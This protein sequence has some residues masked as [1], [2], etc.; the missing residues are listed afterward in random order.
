MKNQKAKTIC[1]EQ[2]EYAVLT[3]HNELNLRDVVSKLRNVFRNSYDN[4]WMDLKEIT[5]T[6][7]TS[8]SL[9]DLKN[10]IKGHQKSYP[11][12]TVVVVADTE[13]SQIIA[14]TTISLLKLDG[15]KG[16]AQLFSSKRQA[17]RWGKLVDL[18]NSECAAR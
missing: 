1:P 11:K 9:Y 4:V 17:I 12:G 6:D 8:E 16:H 13:L 10:F 7:F 5:K 2:T 3:F 14:K 18:L 15:F